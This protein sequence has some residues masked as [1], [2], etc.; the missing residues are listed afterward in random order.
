MSAASVGEVLEAAA[1]IVERDGWCQFRMCDQD[2]GHC[3]LAAI[4]RAD[5]Y[6]CGAT[7]FM[8]TILG[9]SLM[10]WND[11]PERTKEEVVAA[12]RAAALRAGAKT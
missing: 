3:A 1:I 4:I 6:R 10:E 2:G 9:G 11:A 8:R 7:A 12:L 5:V